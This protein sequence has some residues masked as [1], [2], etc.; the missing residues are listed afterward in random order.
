L[1]DR[2][3]DFFENQNSCYI[4]FIGSLDRR[5]AAKPRRREEWA[6]EALRLRDG[7]NPLERLKIAKG[8]E[9]AWI[10]LPSVWILLPGDFENISTGLEKGFADLENVSPEALR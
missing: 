3:L 5:R 10:F 4:T 8:K 7:P 6:N 1:K 9:S 2:R